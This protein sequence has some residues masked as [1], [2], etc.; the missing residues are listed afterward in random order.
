MSYFNSLVK[1]RCSFVVIKTTKIDDP[2]TSDF[3]EEE[4]NETND[5]FCFGVNKE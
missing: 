4:D 2:Q 3:I 1:K 5:D